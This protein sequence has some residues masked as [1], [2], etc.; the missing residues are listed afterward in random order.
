MNPRGHIFIVG[1]MGS[2]K[3]TTGRLLADRLGL[4]FLDLDSEI[5][6]LRGLTIPEIFT[7][8]GEESFRETESQALRT[9]IQRKRSVIALGGGAF[10]PAGNRTVIQRCGISIWLRIDLQAAWQRCSLSS[11]PLAQDYDT[12][13]RL[14]AERQGTYARADLVVDVNKHDPASVVGLA[15]K[16][17]EE[18]D[19]ALDQDHSAG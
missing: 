9:A 8:D 3:T 15:R 4:P 5:Q 16:K 6:R 12:F 1:F 10:A 14:F 11:R 2:G 7:L 18:A 17:L 13:A 19:N